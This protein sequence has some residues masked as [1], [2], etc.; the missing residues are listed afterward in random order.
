M[1]NCANCNF[2]LNYHSETKTEICLKKLSKKLEGRNVGVLL[3][4]NQ[5][6]RILADI[7]G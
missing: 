5:H 1:T 3:Q 4:V 7:F 2:D 6:N